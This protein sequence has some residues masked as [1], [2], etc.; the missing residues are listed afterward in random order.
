MIFYEIYVLSAS[1]QF[2][3]YLIRKLYIFQSSIFICSQLLASVPQ[4]FAVSGFAFRISC[5][6][7]FWDKFCRR[8]EPNYLRAA[9]YVPN[10]ND[11]DV[12]AQI[13]E[14]VGRDGMAE[15]WCRNGDCSKVETFLVD[16][17]VFKEIFYLRFMIIL[18][19]TFKILP[20]PSIT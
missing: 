4:Q 12:M 15:I 1:W 11:F 8:A 13:K 2:I 9:I 14:E 17:E 18:F 7:N 6:Q 19:W 16:I 5:V 10:L 3:R 20:P